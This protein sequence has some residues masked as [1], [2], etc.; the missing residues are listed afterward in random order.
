MCIRDRAIRPGQSNDL[1]VRVL[2]PGDD[3]IDGMVLVETPHLDKA[4]NYSNGNLYDYGGIIDSVE[5]LLTPAARI[6]GVHISPDWKTGLVKVR[7][8]VQNTSGKAGH[9]RVRF[10]VTGTA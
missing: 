9:G 4:V 3:R 7:A 8:A 2:N 1:A 5:L 10:T 6:T